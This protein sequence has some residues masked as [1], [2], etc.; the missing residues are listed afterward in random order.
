MKLYLNQLMLKVVILDVSPDMCSTPEVVTRCLS[1]SG[2]TTIWSLS[3]S[4][5][6][7]P[8]QYQEVLPEASPMIVPKL[9]GIVFLKI[10]IANYNFDPFL[11]SFDIELLWREL[12]QVLCNAI[13]SS[14][15]KV[16]QRKH[17]RPKWFTPK[18]QHELNCVYTLRKKPSTTLLILINSSWYIY[19]Y[20]Y[21]YLQKQI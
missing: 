17:Q 1:I 19:I 11:H 15:P 9:I 2:L 3:Q 12:K 14:I 4:F 8:D 18:I 5:L 20:I 13:D 21:I 10:L 7:H 6:I 16:Y